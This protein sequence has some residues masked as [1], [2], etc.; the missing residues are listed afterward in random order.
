VVVGV[1]AVTEMVVMPLKT[2]TGA[3]VMV[4][5]SVDVVVVKKVVVVVVEVRVEVIQSEVSVSVIVNV[6]ASGARFLRRR[7][8]ARRPKILATL[9]GVS[10]RKAPGACVIAAAAGAGAAVRALTAGAS[11]VTL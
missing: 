3:G 1:G 6:G 10:R 2:V 8:T 9:T 5:A 7:S 4:V 11:D